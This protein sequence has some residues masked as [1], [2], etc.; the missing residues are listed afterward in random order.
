MET[1]FIPETGNLEAILISCM[2]FT[3][4]RETEIKSGNKEV[5]KGDRAAS[6][7]AK[8]GGKNRT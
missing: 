3:G 4:K 5:W 2:R 6:Q 8:S 1:I 7:I